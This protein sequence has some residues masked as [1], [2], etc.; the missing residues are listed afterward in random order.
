M[1][2]GEEKEEDN[3]EMQIDDML[4]DEYIKSIENIYDEYARLSTLA[5]L[6]SGT[7]KCMI[8]MTIASLFY[9]VVFPEQ[10]YSLLLSLISFSVGSLFNV[11]NRCEILQKIIHVYGDHNYNTPYSTAHI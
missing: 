1:K 5:R 8:L 10:H 4:L 7:N 9:S 3:I 11:Q 2:E 6:Y